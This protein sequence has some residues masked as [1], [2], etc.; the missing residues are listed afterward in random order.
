MAKQ[1]DFTLKTLISNIILFT[2]LIFLTSGL[3]K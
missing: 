1:R 2:T 3:E